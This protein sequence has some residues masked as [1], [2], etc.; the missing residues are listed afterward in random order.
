M[1]M[2]G[3]ALINF[4]SIS[5]EAPLLALGFAARRWGLEG[6]PAS[7]VATTGSL[8]VIND[9]LLNGTG[10]PYSCVTDLQKTYANKPP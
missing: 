4:T 6:F 9:G 7:L 1:V 2:E 3:F 8:T 10:M 5:E